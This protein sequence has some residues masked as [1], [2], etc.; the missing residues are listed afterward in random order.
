M[1]EVEGV[2]TRGALDIINRWVSEFAV[3]VGGHVVFVAWQLRFRN[4]HN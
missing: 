2:N 1:V 4:A 3:V